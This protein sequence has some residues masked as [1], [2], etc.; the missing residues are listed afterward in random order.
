MVS[1]IQIVITMLLLMVITCSCK[2][3]LSKEDWTNKG[4]YLNMDGKYEESIKCYDKAIEIDPNYIKAW[5]NKGVALESLKKYEEAIKCFDK[6]IQINP[7]Y[8]YIYFIWL[9][10]GADLYSLKKYEEAIKC[11]DKAIELDPNN[12]DAKTAKEK[13]LKAL[14]K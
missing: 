10:K 12:A 11:L 7:N 6:V 5:H 13:V 14:G 4:I 1:N 8:E 3:F 2:L 9:S